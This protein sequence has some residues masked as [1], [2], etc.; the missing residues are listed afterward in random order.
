VAT[1]ETYKNQQGEKATNTEW[2][3]I[4]AFDKLAGIVE[5]YFTKGSKI[6]VE[7]KIQTK[8]YETQ[9][10]EKRYSTSILMNGFDFAGSNNSNSQEPK[11]T[12]DSNEEEQ[13]PLPF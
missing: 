13:D 1:T 6:L 12:P 9:E 11:N 3:N 2:H 8:S 5:S 7:G 10:G 4:V